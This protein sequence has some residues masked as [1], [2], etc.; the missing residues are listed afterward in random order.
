MAIIISNLYV[1]NNVPDGTTIGVLTTIDQSGTVIPCNYILKKGSIGY[2]AIAGN[3]LV[4]AWSVPATPGRYSVRIRAIGSSTIFSSSA[5]FTVEVGTAA[6]P[7]PPPPPPSPPPPPPLAPTPSPPPAPPPPATSIMVD[8]ANNTMVAEG[9]ALMVNV[10]NGPG[11]TTDWVGLAA[12]GT[13]DTAF[14]AWAYLNG[15]QTPPAAG[16]TSATVMMTA[17]TSDGPYEARFY[18]NNLWTVTARSSFTVVGVT[19]A[20]PPP[21]P[22]EPPPPAAVITITPNTPQVPDT[23]SVGAVVATYTV[24]MR[25]D[26]RL[27]ERSA[28]ARLISMPAASS[29]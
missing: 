1:G 24:T 6:P 28:L 3:N 10:A 11:D 16:V 20:P 19:P 5:T 21:P 14:I 25:T 17:P 29:H 22:P 8:G 13:P 2:F 12:A 15:T 26:R 27:S 9:A 4:T 23:T 18:P 7:P